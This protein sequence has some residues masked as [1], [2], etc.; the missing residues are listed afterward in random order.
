MQE[1]SKFDK[2]HKFAPAVTFL[3]LEIFALLAFSFGDN[4]IVYSSL[5]LGLV[6]LLILFNL[7]QIKIDGIS[8][9]ALFIFPLFL[10]GLLGALGL[11]SR[12]HLVLGDYN[13]AELIFFPIGLLA[14]AFSGY[15][16]TLEKSFKIQTFLVVIY[17]A[18]AVITV[19]NII[20]NIVNF[21]F[22]YTIFY[23]GYYMYYQGAA[24]SV[25][26]EE[27]AYTL[28]GLQFVEVKMSQYLVNPAMLL[29]SSIALFFIPFKDKK[30]FFLFAGYSFI[31]VLALI[32]FPT[33]LG[34]IVALLVLVVDAIIY[35][36]YRFKPVRKPLKIVL[37]VLL[38]IIALGL[39]AVILNYNFDG[40]YQIT[41]GNA[42][43]D[44]LFNTNKYIPKYSEA[45]R[46]LAYEHRFF[47]GTWGR[48][49]PQGALLFQLTGSFLFDNIATTGIIGSLLFIVMFVMGFKSF[50]KYIV[51]VKEE[52]LFCKVL[53]LAFVSLFTI[54]GATFLEGEYT[55]FHN[56]LRPIYMSPIFMICLF[57]F[58][59]VI[60]KANPVKEEK[61]EEVTNEQEA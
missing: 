47:L 7:R 6:I 36:V 33:L 41:K 13:L 3:A 55:I 35:V 28:Q 54:M 17:S 25:P 10:Y 49:T 18:L 45:V 21:G 60:T 61:K 23:K 15:L 38:G 22:F 5:S 11:F 46:E 32:F 4:V 40:V 29:T 57:M 27:M 12:A 31:G 39:L 56:V 43:L 26:V 34:G 42:F 8:N 2:L 51:N 1:T 14:I 20:A 52:P 19:I 30:K 50:K 44:R 48:D 16:I 9:I 53:V 37:F 59:Y 24:S 58:V